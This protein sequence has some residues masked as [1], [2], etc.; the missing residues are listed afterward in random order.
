[1][2]PLNQAEPLHAAS[3]GKKAST[4][5]GSHDTILTESKH[6]DVHTSSRVLAPPGGRC[7]NIFG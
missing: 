7:H 2:K 4:M 6:R 1:M 3:Y 5:H